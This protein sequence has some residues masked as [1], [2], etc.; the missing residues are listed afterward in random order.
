ML[1][2]ASSN[3][4]DRAS[5]SLAVTQRAVRIRWHLGAALKAALKAAAAFRCFHRVTGPPRGGEPR[6]QT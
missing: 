4:R 2:R 6:C 3:D 1:V 5:L